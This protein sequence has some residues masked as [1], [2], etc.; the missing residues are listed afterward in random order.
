MK[1]GDSLVFIN[2]MILQLTCMSMCAI[3]LTHSFFT[4]CKIVKFKVDKKKKNSLQLGDIKVLEAKKVIFSSRHGLHN[5]I[6]LFQ[7]KLGTCLQNHIYKKCGSFEK[8]IFPQWGMLKF[9]SKCHFLTIKETSQN[10]FYWIS[11]QWTHVLVSPLY[12]GFFFLLKKH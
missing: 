5:F 9:K 1:F 8:Y 2:N 7:G 3:N 11:K 6:F 12:M 10:L 4:I